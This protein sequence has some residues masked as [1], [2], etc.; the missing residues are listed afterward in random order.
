MFKNI[1]A[2]LIGK[3]WSVLSN[4][5]FIP[6][7]IKYLGFESYSIISFTLVIVGLMAV[8][9]S[10]LTA[11]LSREFAREDN[12]LTDKI[13]IFKTVESLYFIII[14]V[15]II[16]LYIL[17]DLIAFKWLNLIKLNPEKISI[18]VKIISIG[19]GFQMLLRFYMGGLLGLEKQIEANVYQILWGIVRNGMVILVIFFLPSLEVFFIWQTVT[20]VIFALVLKL[21]LNKHLTGKYICNLMP[22]IDR[23]VLSQIWRFAG[24]M[25]L[26]SIVASLNS[27][28]DKL[29]ISKYLAVESLG[30]YTLA[31]SLSMSIY[32]FV[33][34]ISV[35]LLP[36]FT[37]LFSKGN[38]IEASLLFSK[39][40]VYVGIIVFAIMANMSFFGEELIWVWTGDKQ[41]AA[42]AYIYLPIISISYTML[43]LSI[44]PYNIAIANGYT[45]LNNLLGLISLFI[46]LPG[47]WIATKYY[48]GIGA[49]SVFCIV[50]ISATLIYIFF[51]KKKFLKEVKLKSLYANQILFPLLISIV[52]V[53]VFSSLKP[54]ISV[55]RIEILL[56]VGFSTFI[57]I[58]ISSFLLIPMDQIKQ[59]AN[60]KFIKN[61]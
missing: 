8:L 14:S 27:Q 34:P 58:L 42:E 37:A 25:L 52:L 12:S 51:I 18:Y 7:Y 44:L 24:G 47:Y 16:V 40:N 43:S 29:A 57:T 45:K 31:V 17:S 32:I 11:T 48:G 49:A 1:I 35:A 3:F 22:K 38:S 23:A 56:W 19:V 55:G 26:I 41:L 28:M 59:I 50:Q 30:Y 20:K 36:R 10:G 4:F 15:S 46:T 60:L 6:L 2:N 53:Y 9:D 21:T 33:G 61:K 54:S 39:V 5:L 13:K